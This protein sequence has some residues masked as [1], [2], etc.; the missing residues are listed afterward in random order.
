MTPAKTNNVQPMTS[1][2]IVIFP[3]LGLLPSFGKM[4]LGPKLH[5][6]VYI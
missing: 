3:E 5:I 6:L 4:K 1:F 2:K